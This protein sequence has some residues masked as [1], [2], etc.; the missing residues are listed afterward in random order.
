MKAF[1]RFSTEFQTENFTCACFFGNDTLV[2]GNN[3]GELLQYSISNSELIARHEAHDMQSE[4]KSVKPYNSDCLLSTA[5]D[6]ELK[7]WKFFEDTLD[8][9]NQINLEEKSVSVSVS[10]DSRNIIVSLLNNNLKVISGE[11]FK[12]RLNL[13]GNALPVMCSDVSFDSK[14]LAT[15]SL[16]KNIKFWGLNFGDCHSSRFAHDD[17]VLAVKFKPDSLICY[18]AGK[19]GIIKAWDSRNA[20]FLTSINGNSCVF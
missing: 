6:G 4:I 14:V 17:G 9:Q 19:D 7:R 13:Y 11:T 3:R 10:P 18:S 8:L 12:V 2:A 5:Q 1:R 20:S 15:G 16:D